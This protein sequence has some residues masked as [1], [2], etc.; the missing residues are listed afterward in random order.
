MQQS[1]LCFDLTVTWTSKPT[2]AKAHFTSI[3]ESR[4]EI[5]INESTFVI[6]GSDYAIAT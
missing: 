2:M 3:S 6:V 5:N 1:K 4:D